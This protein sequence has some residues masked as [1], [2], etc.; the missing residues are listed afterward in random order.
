MNSIEPFLFKWE[1]KGV[2]TDDN[3]QRR[4]PEWE[5]DVT[6]DFI[7]HQAASDLC[8]EISTYTL[9]EK[10]AEIVASEM[11]PIQDVLPLPIE[12]MNMGSVSSRSGRQRVLYVRGESVIVPS[13]RSEGLA[14]IISNNKNAARDLRG[15][16]SS[17]LEEIAGKF[18]GAGISELDTYTAEDFTLEHINH[19]NAEINIELGDP[20]EFEDQVMAELTPLSEAF[21]SNVNVEFIEYSPNP[22]FDIIFA[23]GPWGLLQ[24]EVKDYAA[25]NNEPGKE[26]A[27]HRPLR[28]A[29]LL[30]IDQT[31]T[32]LKGVENQTMEELKM[33]SELRNK[34][35]VVE[36]SELVETIE[37]LLE[38]T[39]GGRPGFIPLR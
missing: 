27:I 37:P 13:G 14:R 36:K 9:Q 25:T 35:Q 4:F 23:S 17:K 8:D 31:V 6:T 30:N 18:H 2:Q 39:V 1:G 29:S 12:E 19:P 3:Y 16:F 34:I 5:W 32:V 15:K 20:D 33:D 21:V 26:E 7:F 28:K 10:Y 11:E 24:I 22:E 38:R